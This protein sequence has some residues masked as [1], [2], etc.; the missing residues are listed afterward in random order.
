[1]VQNSVPVARMGSVTTN[2]QFIRQIGAAFGVSSFGL[3]VTVGE[4]RL[5]LLLLVALSAGTFACVLALPTHSL[6]GD[7]MRK[8]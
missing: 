2:Q 8:S 1:V 4:F 7:E 5:G 3:A 6:H